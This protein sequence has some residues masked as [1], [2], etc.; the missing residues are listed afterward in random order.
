MFSPLIFKCVYTK[1]CRSFVFETCFTQSI[2]SCFNHQS[3]FLLIFSLFVKYWIILPF[4][5]QR[6]ILLNW[7]YTIPAEKYAASPDTHI[8]TKLLLRLRITSTSLGCHCQVDLFLSRPLS[9]YTALSFCLAHSLQPHNSPCLIIHNG[10]IS[11]Y[12]AKQQAQE[13]T[14][15][16]AFCKAIYIK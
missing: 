5:L 11:L 12:S 3:S 1:L 2:H 15:T 4:Y 7:H 8:Q 13:N 9:L 16:D 6:F 10:F 14:F